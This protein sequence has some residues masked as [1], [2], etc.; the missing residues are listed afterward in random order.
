MTTSLT[1]LDRLER[2]DDHD[3]WHR[4]VDIYLPL[5]RGWLRM[6][7]VSEQEAD[8]LSQD[9]LAVV[10]RELPRFRHNERPGAF[11][12]WLRTITVH[13]VRQQW[14]QRREVTAPE[15]SNRMLDQLE[16]PHSDL[17]L[18]WDREHDAYVV[19]RLLEVVRG[20]CRPAA[21]Q[22]FSRQVLDGAPAETVASELDTTA[23]AVLIAKSRVLR[24]LRQHAEGLIDPP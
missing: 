3:A 9:V 11:R 18:Q 5:I 4:L 12:A 20:E 21:W 1:L 17:S 10:V 2:G 14:R 7:H 24:R 16:D 22:A 19:G 23:N 13:R 8:D 15:Q 6:L